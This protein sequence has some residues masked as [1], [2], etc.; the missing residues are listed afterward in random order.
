MKAIWKDTIIAESNETVVIEH[1]HYFPPESLKQKHFK[2]SDHTTSCSW[3]GIASY[4]HIEVNGE[5]NINA[6][7]CYATPKNIV[8]EIRGRIAFWEGVEVIE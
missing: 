6:A 2:P 5:T 8:K 4:Y 3:K 1:N 7:W